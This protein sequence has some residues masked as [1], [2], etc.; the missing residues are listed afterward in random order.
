MRRVKTI[1]ALLI[2]ALWL[3]ASSHAL[4]QHL[5]YIH[6]AHTHDESVDADHH[7]DSDGSH[8]H[9]TDNHAAADGL[10]LVSSGKVSA[11]KPVV[12]AT[13]P[14][15]KAATVLSGA[16][17]ATSFERHSGPSPPGVAPPELSHRW[18]FSFRAA[19]P[20]RAPS[21]IS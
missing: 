16:D 10:C 7:E 4:L 12:V 2:A 9:D 11:A 14:W 5:G 1:V 19:L 13:L 15:L 6:Q 20:V 21:F 18:Q 17:I 3:P 8:E